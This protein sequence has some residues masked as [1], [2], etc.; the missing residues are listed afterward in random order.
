MY[1][2]AFPGP[3]S[4]AEA[5]YRIAAAEIGYL[6]CRNSVGALLSALTPRLARK[7]VKHERL[8]AA[9]LSQ[10]YTFQFLVAAHTDE[11]FAYQEAALKR[12]VED[13][14]GV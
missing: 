8:R 10:R 1:I 3:D 9:L 14:G 6:H 5:G 4:F 2:C 7:L 13:T 11:E 12:I